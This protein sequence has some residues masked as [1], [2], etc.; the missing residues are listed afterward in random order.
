MSSTP[1]RVQ[2]RAPLAHPAMPTTALLACGPLAAAGSL[3][4]SCHPSIHCRCRAFHSLTL[5]IATY[6]SHP[7]PPHTHIYQHHRGGTFQQKTQWMSSLAA[8]SPPTFQVIAFEMPAAQL[9]RAFLRAFGAW[10]LCLSAC[11]Q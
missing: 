4:A 9:A 2:A 3:C 6:A 11:C 10:P 8:R 7:P 5:H 1:R